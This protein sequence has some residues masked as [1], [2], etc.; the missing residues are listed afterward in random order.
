MRT[1]FDVLISDYTVLE[2]LWGMR[3]VRGIAEKSELDCFPV[4]NNGKIIG[5]LTRGD[6]IKSHPNRIVM[7]AMS[8]SYKFIGAG[9]S[10]W[11]AKKLLDEGNDILIITKE[12]KT[13]GIITKK[14]IEV[15]IGKHIDLLTG[16]Y[17]SDYIMYKSLE[18]LEQSGEISIIFFDV[19]NFGYIDKEYG[20]A[21]GDTVL[22]EAARILE[23]NAPDQ[24]YLCRYG[25]DEFAILTDECAEKCKIMAQDILDKVKGHNFYE[26]IHI[27]ISA[28]IAGGRRSNPR[29]ENLYKTVM[30]LINLASLASTK[31]KK[32]KENLVLGYNGIIDERIS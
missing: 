22:K 11:K 26:G 29:K 5:A 20:H 24:S 32:E 19:N 13:I 8:G 6:L 2:G 12:G 17:K 3:R 25:G 23:G 16:L 21:V 15:E 4:A 1:V 9:E 18:L 10:V 7:D 27:D 28:G 31:A 14:A 30:N